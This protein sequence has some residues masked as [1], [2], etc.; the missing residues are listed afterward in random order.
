MAGRKV[1]PRCTEYQM[2]LEDFTY[3]NKVNIKRIFPNNGIL[4][5]NNYFKN[6]ALPPHPLQI[7]S[8]TLKNKATCHCKVCPI[9]SQQSTLMKLT[10]DCMHKPHLAGALP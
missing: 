8:L 2:K 10:L 1:N 5:P 3:L 9:P 7:N 4:K 6:S